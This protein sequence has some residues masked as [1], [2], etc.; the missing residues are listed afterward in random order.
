MKCLIVALTPWLCTP[1]DIADRGARRE[2]R[3]FAEVFEIPAIQRR[4]IN[5]HSRSQHESG[6]RG[7]ARLGR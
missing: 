6:L 5:V 4:A 1:S 2:E 3:V 7:R